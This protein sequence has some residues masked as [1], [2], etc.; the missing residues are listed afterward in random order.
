MLVVAAK[1]ARDF[2]HEG[3]LAAG[4]IIGNLVTEDDQC[5]L[6]LLPGEG[7]YGGAEIVGAAEPV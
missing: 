2:D 7:E 4:G 6:V 1:G 5:A 3:G